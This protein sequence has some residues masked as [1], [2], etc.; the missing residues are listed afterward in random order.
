MNV[1]ETKM[2]AAINA[3]QNWQQGATE[4]AVSDA[5]NVQV[6]LYGSPIVRLENGKKDIFVSLA[7]YNTLTTRSRINVV[8]DTFGVSRVGNTGG[9]PYIGG[10]K[11]Q[12]GRDWYQVMRAGVEIP[13]EPVQA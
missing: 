3:G 1:I 6:M 8:L 9:M 11:I 12:T 4:V 2:L 5:G 13:A 10:V 7:G